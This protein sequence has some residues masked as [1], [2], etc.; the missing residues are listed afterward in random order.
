M[1][2]DSEA[3]MK[4]QRRL[5]AIILLCVLPATLITMAGCCSPKPLPPAASIPEFAAL[6]AAD[7]QLAPRTVRIPVDI[8][9][10]GK[11]QAELAIQE[12]GAGQSERIIVF[13]HG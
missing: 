7:D 10:A 5:G 3:V 13:I 1:N 4:Y 9:A 6:A 8:D 12:T 2:V 11:H